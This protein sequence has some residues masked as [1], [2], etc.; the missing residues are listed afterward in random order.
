[1]YKLSYESNPSNVD[2][3]ILGKGLSENAALKKGH[4]AVELFVFFIR[5]E[6]NEIVGGCNGCNLYGCLVIDQLWLSE[7][8]RG[9]GY[10]TQL[11]RAAEAWGKEHHCVFAAVNTMDWEALEFYKKFGYQIE[12]ERRGFLNESV[13]YFLRKD[14]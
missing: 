11:V 9:Q 8:L 7:P 5:D 14:L 13:F 12:F 6:K 1:M 3:A 10:G 2:I 4:K